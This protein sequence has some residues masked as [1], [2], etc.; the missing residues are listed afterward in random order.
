MEVNPCE[1]LSEH[2][3]WTREQHPQADEYFLMA[4]LTEEGL[5]VYENYRSLAER[6]LG[7]PLEP[8]P[9]T[10]AGDPRRS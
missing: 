3:D 9:G 4:E 1:L 2:E 8:P 6:L 7:C 10:P 5:W